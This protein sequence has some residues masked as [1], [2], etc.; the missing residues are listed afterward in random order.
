MTPTV[1][2][3]PDLTSIFQKHQ[4]IKILQK[5]FLAVI[6]IAPP[7]AVRLR[8]VHLSDVYLI[9]TLVTASVIGLLVINCNFFDSQ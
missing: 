3:G 6:F 4:K 5:Y 7:M 2:C 1:D 8:S 9:A